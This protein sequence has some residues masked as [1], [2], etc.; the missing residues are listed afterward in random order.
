M[1]LWRGQAHFSCSQE[2]S[3]SRSQWAEIVGRT[4]NVVV[5]DEVL[6]AVRGLVL[7]IH[8]AMNGVRFRGAFLDLFE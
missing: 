3:S 2:R 4:P 7:M 5:K 6:D 1:Q 8:E